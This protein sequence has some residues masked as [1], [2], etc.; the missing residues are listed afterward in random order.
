M[1][2]CRSEPTIAEM[3]SDPIVKA[4]MAADRVAPEELEKSLSKIAARL[5]HRQVP[6]ATLLMRQCAQGIL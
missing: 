6:A 3:L 1:H 4:L 2:W 5:D